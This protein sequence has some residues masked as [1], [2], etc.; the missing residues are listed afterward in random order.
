MAWV[1]PPP[2]PTW[3]RDSTKLP[4]LEAGLP[5]EKRM[6]GVVGLLEEDEAGR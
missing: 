2:P 4:P 3:P 1:G 6:S 5:W